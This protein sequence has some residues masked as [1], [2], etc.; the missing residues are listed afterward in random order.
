MA[1]TWVEDQVNSTLHQARKR[2]VRNPC[3]FT[4]LESDAYKPGIKYEV[5]HRQPLLSHPN[6]CS[7]IGRPRLEPTGLVV[8]AV[9]GQI[10]FGRKSYNLAISQ[11]RNAVVNRTI[12]Q[13]GQTYG[14]DQ[15]SSCRCQ[16]NQLLHSR[17]DKTCGQK[18]ILGTIAGQ[19]K[20]RQA[21]NLNTGRAR[22]GQG[23]T[24][25]S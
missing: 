24:D 5:T 2:T 10:L 20:F 14:G 6:V 22:F 21:K 19:A 25:S 7:M 16:T 3:I 17:F 12:D 18:H 15:T 13:Q 8:K 23:N 9:F 1:G 11:N 4:D